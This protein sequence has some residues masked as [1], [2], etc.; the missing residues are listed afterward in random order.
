MLLLIH[1]RYHI[2]EV[3]LKRVTHE[4]FV[5]GDYM[6]KINDYQFDLD[7]E[8]RDKYLD[9]IIYVYPMNC[10]CKVDKVKDGWIYIANTFETKFKEWE[11]GLTDY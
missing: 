7:K 8:L 1:K 11:V 9:K 6:S 10:F 3:A 2:I 5:R 4:I